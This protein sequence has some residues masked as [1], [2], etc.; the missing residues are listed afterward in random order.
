MEVLLVC[1]FSFSSSLKAFHRSSVFLMQ[2]LTDASS[3]QFT[4]SRTAVL[5]QCY[6][7][8]SGWKSPDTTGFSS[9]FDALVSLESPA[10][11][12]SIHRSCS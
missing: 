1:E 2:T 3:S 7:L 11:N 5:S 9:A 8:L 4:S 10:S 6:F 12:F